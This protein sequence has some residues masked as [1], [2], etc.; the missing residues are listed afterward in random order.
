MSPIIYFLDDQTQSTSTPTLSLDSPSNAG[1]VSSTT[2]QLKFTGASNA[3]QNI[4][5]EIQ[6]DSGNTFNSQAGGAN[7]PMSKH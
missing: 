5:Y 2:P 7:R 1:T 6:I 3:S 4:P